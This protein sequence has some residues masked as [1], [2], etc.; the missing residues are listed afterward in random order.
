[1]TDQSDSHD[2]ANQQLVNVIMFND[3]KFRDRRCCSIGVFP[4]ICL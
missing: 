4:C 3:L 2:V 1:M